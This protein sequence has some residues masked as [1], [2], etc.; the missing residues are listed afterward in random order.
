MDNIRFAIIGCGARGTGLYGVALKFRK[1]LDYV[2]VCDTYEDK[3]NFLAQKIANDGHSKPKTYTDYKKM[4]DEEKIDAVL[5][6]TGWKEHIPVTM[7]AMEKGIAV[8]CEVG[9]AYTLEDLWALVNCYEKTKTPVMMLENC[10][11][12]RL[13]LMALKM[14][15]AGLFGE[16]VHCEC[17]YRHD[18]RDEI[19]D[20][21]Q[22]R[23]YRKRQYET[24]NCDNYP[25]HGIGPVA[26]ILDINCGNKF[27]TISSIGSKSVG[28]H[29]F[30]VRHR[31]DDKELQNVRFNQSD[32][33]TSMIKCANGET[34]TV[35]LDTALPRYY[36]RDF[37]IQGTLGMLDE[38][39]NAV[40]L[41]KDG[42][43]GKYPHLPQYIN[44]MDTYY[45][46]Y[47]HPLWKNFDAT[48]LGHGGMDAQVFSAFFNALHDNKP[49]PVDVYDYAAWASIS[50]L[51][52]KSLAT[53]GT[54]VTF[55]DFTRGEWTTRKNTFLEEYD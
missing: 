35:T 36:S 10:C 14:K 20:G 40:F 53:G 27:L 33:V 13:E 43:H 1:D 50:V 17:G 42:P 41:E 23:S 34:V 5:I 38:R 32:V 51:S 19:C 15:R 49:M 6:A 9:G 26:K 44:N 18:I 8:G 11:F 3:A 28:M 2:A 22:L 31:S 54:P 47:E 7:Y 48:G 24:W 30:A 16:I 29:D 25:T 37:F 55:P 45:E 12:G 21:N 39:G 52:E 4:F 46:K